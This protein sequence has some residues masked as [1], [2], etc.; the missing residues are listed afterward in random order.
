MEACARTHTHAHVIGIILGGRFLSV[1]LSVV[2]ITKL[3]IAKP[4]YSGML[5]YVS[6]CG[7]EKCESCCSQWKHI[8]LALP[9]MD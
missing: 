1:C 7:V 8:I 4:L 5:G 9:L 2:Y 3:S 6:Y